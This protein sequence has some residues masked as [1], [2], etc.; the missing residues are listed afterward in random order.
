M[1]AKKL[2][3]I[4]TRDKLF[5]KY[6]QACDNYENWKQKATDK[7][8]TKSSRTRAND[9][10]KLMKKHIQDISSEMIA[11]DTLITQPDCVEDLYYEISEVY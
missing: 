2:A 8:G 9:V 4:N 10:V 6:L 11:L 3:L 1:T 5:D 7:E